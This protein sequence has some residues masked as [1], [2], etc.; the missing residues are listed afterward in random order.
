MVGVRLTFQAGMTQ[1]LTE[2]HADW[3]WPAAEKLGLPT[4]FFSP[5]NVP[6]FAPIAARHPGLPL[7]IDHMSLNAEIVEAGA[8]KQ[9]IDDVV[10]L[11]KYPNVSVKVSSTPTHSR[12]PYPFKDMAEHIKRCF[13]AYGPQR[14][15]WG[16]DIT[17]SLAKASYRQRITHFTEGLPFLSE[18]DKDW[19][20][21]KAILQTLKWT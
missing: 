3:Y 4:M 14:C 21:G 13:D 19:V 9:S 7:I 6:K 10:A 11:A 18:S 15:Y 12:Q 16:T 17:N 2:G 1:L 20:M 8:I 5:T